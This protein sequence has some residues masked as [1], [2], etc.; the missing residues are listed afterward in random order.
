[1]HFLHSLQ[2]QFWDFHLLILFLKALKLG[3]S[4][5]S[6]GTK[7]QIFDPRYKKISVPWK[8][9]FTFITENSGVWRKL[10]WTL[11]FEKVWLKMAE[12]RSSL[13]LK[14]SVVRICINVNWNVSWHRSV[15]FSKDD[16]LSL[17]T[18]RRHDAHIFRASGLFYYSLFGSETSTLKGSSWTVT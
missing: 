8:V 5:S 4:L 1:M 2:G 6:I 16:V 3:S 11:R 15:C 14:N 13:Y 17:Y 10:Y 9:L 18:M 7:S 12:T